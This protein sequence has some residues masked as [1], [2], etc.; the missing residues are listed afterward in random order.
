MY[1]PIVGKLIY[2]AAEDDTPPGLQVVTGTM[3]LLGFNVALVLCFTLA[4]LTA[5]ISSSIPNILSD[6]SSIL[7]RNST[8]LTNAVTWDSHSLFIQGQ[9][10]FIL[11]GEFHPWRVPNP[12]LW[13]DIFQKIHDNGFNTVSF[14]ID[15]ALHYPTPTTNA[16]NGDWEPGTY[17][18]I[19]A[20]IDGAK[21]A[22]L[23]LIARSVCSF[24]MCINST[25]AFC[26]PGL[27]PTSVCAPQLHF[28]GAN[29]VLDAE[30]S[31][32]GFPGWVSAISGSLR[33]N[34]AA[35]EQ[36]TEILLSIQQRF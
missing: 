29:V 13:Q 33:T 28:S 1:G 7:R 19:Q 8:G 11:S 35:Y 17:R 30:T 18:D 20:F 26:R 27:V 21:N 31:G 32:G 25:H 2:L 24:A 14:Y 10:V 36:G 15:W 23:W 5:A 34:N 3:G 9:R 12:D 22:G 16:G 6:H 4:Q